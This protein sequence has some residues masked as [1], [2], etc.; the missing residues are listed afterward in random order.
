MASIEYL[1]K[2][3][4][5]A[6]AKIEKLQKKLDRIEKAQESGWEINPYCYSEYDLRSTTKKLNAAM[7]SLEKYKN[8]LRIEQEKSASRDVQVIIDFLEMWK[9]HVEDYYHDRFDEYMEDREEY[10]TKDR[11]FTNWY[12]NGGYRDSNGKQLHKEHDDYCKAFHSRWRFLSPYTVR[13]GGKY[14]LDVNKLRKDLDQ[15][16]AQKYD[17][18]IERTNKIVGQITDASNLSVGAS[19]DLNGYIIGT[20]GTAKVTTI[21]AGGYNIQCYHFRTLI[22]KA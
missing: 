16:A 4:E 7:Q 5:G 12:N 9:D 6:E 13:R 19:G 10:I 20:N 8:D 14:V 22:H 17:H 18:I 11:E 21:G 2:R 1:T 15:E 3:I